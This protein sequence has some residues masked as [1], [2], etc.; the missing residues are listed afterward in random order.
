M[1][2]IFAL[3]I[4]ASQLIGFS[5]AQAQLQ[6]LKSATYNGAQFGSQS[7]KLGP[8]VLKGSSIVEVLIN[9][10]PRRC[11][12]SA[13]QYCDFTYLEK[14][15][16][17]YKDST[18]T[19][20]DETVKALTD[21]K[22][23]IIKA[24]ETTRFVEFNE[25]TSIRVNQGGSVRFVSSI[26][27]KQATQKLT[28]VWVYIRKESGTFPYIYNL[29]PDRTSGIANSKRKVYDTPTWGWVNA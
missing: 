21:I 3:A 14:T 27:R 28:G 2:N 8:W 19:T 18:G 7:P 6:V 13:A 17:M 15:G 26:E 23:A 24:A 11:T 29:Y 9:S 20:V 16:T 1:R 12:A 5:Q 25:G 10:A 22:T 4:I